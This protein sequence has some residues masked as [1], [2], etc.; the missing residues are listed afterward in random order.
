MAKAGLRSRQEPLKRETSLG[1][2]TAILLGKKDLPGQSY[3]YSP[4]EERLP[5][6]VLL[7]L[8]REENYPAQCTPAAPATVGDGRDTVGDGAVPWVV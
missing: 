4:R 7:L 2:V 1:R 6:P 3:R 8:L 5:C